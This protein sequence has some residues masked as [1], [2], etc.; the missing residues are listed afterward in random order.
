MHSRFPG[1]LRFFTGIILLIVLFASCSGC[2]TSGIPKQPL[3]PEKIIPPQILPEEKPAVDPVVGT[4][5]GFLATSSGKNSAG[6]PSLKDEVAKIRLNI[7]PDLTFEYTTNFTIR[8]GTLIPTGKGNFIVRAN[9]TET[10][11]KYFRYDGEGD[12][13]KWE[14]QDLVIE[15]RRN[16]HTFSAS[17]LLEYNTLMKK[18]FSEEQVAAAVT[19]PTPVPTHA[20]AY[21]QS[22][23]F[24]YDPHEVAWQLNGDVFIESGKYDS[25]GI[26]LRYPDNDEYQLDVGG[27]GGANFT[28]KEFKMILNDRVRNQTPAFFIRLGSAEYSTVQTGKTT[29]YVIY[30]SYTNATMV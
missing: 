13:L 25:V 28:K 1:T 7:Y 3:I 6:D 5:N 14:S 22:E 9:E 27:M 20:V 15:F 26:I 11:R 19:T 21:I 12:I 29:D 18:I 30:T 2:V 24:G 8:N 23:G 10:E 17:E 16:D 4:W